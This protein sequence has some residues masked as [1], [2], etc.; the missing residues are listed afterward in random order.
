VL[1]GV[2][3]LQG[4]GVALMPETSAPQ[5]GA[6]ASIRPTF[7]MPPQT[8]G[9]LLLA[10]PALVAVWALAGLYGAL[11]P[12]LVRLVSGSGSIVLGGLSLAVL[13][14][15][16][17]VAVLALQKQSPR[18]LTLIGGAALIA[19]VG[20]TVLSVRFGS[21]AGFFG[22]TAIAGVGFGGGFQGAIRSVVPLAA[23]HQRAGVLSVVYVVSYLA[24]GLPAV[25]AGVLLVHEGNLVATA[26]QYGVAVMVLTAVA[27]L[28]V[29]RPPRPAPEP[30]VVRDI[31]PEQ[32]REM[33]TAQRA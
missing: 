22:G 3:L 7:A 23:P 16:G 13:A 17:A 6:L 14:A 27:L 21:V 12:A 31:E 20:L 15:S 8:R 33:C 30:E 18:T 32:A 2:F 9:P 29:I 24:M 5:P 25:I 4:L 19:G 1:L 28:G 26:V 11:G 10:V